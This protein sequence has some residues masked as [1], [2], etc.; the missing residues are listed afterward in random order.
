MYHRA[1][2]LGALRQSTKAQSGYSPNE[3][4]AKYPIQSNLIKGTHEY[5]HLYLH[6]RYK[7]STTLGADFWDP[8]DDFYRGTN[9]RAL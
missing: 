1:Q 5:F 6:G 3:C 9:T 2:L 7:Y 8:S 4:I